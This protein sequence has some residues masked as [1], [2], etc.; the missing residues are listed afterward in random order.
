M[1]QAVSEV[2]KAVSD[3]DRNQ[4]HGCLVWE[5]LGQRLAEGR[6]WKAESGPGRNQGHGCLVDNQ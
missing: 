3:P 2:N 5:V 1:Y 4:G 6:G